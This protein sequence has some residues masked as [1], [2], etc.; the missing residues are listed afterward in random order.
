M[1]R[2]LSIIGAA[3]VLTACGGGGDDAPAPT[4]TT[5]AEGFWSGTAS[6]GTDVALAILENGETWGV[7]LS[8]N[9]IVGALYG[10]TSS[11]GSS[12]NGTGS[13]FNIPSRT[14]TPGSYSGT[15]TAKSTISVTT[16]NGGSFTGTYDPVYD[17]TPSLASLAGTFSGTGV[18]ATTAPQTASVTITPTGVITVPASLGCS[19]SGTASPR[20]SGKNIFNINVTFSGTGCALGNGG[21]A[22]GIAYYDT[23]SGSVLVMALNSGK[24]DGFI[25]VGSKP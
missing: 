11:A 3:V 12:L 4:V 5:A 16:S 22:S 18:S 15:F 23:V 8:G 17:A 10:Q 6:T 2:I 21:M 7:Y 14:V 13:D 9:T 20:P 1:K 24:T 19:A 25:Y